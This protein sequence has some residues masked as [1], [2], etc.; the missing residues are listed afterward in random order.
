MAEFRGHII[1]NNGRNLLSRA[2]AGAGKII[3]TKAA[4]GD[5]KYNDNFKEVTA[6]K[7]KKLDLNVMG[8]R[9]D[10][11]T[12]IL[13]VFITNQDVTE[14]FLTQEF[15]IFAKIEG[16]ESDIL[17]AYTTAIA[18]DA[19]PNNK[20]GTTYESV[21]DIYLA[22]SNDIEADILVKDGVIFLTRDIADQ[23]YTK[24]EYPVASLLSTSSNLKAEHLYADNNGNWYLNIGGER[25]WDRN[26]TP[27][28]NLIKL[29]FRTLYNFYKK[30]FSLLTTKEEKE[31]VT[32][33]TNGIVGGTL[34]PSFIQDSGTKTQGQYYLD[35]NTGKLFQCIQT[36]SSTINSATF[37]K[38]VSLN[39]IVDRL[40]N[41]YNN[42]VESGY[43]KIGRL[44]IQWGYVKPGIHTFPIPFP[45]QVL[46][47]ASSGSG[48]GNGETTSLYII[49][50]NKFNAIQQQGK[51][52]RYIAVGY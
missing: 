39:G 44:I 24:N 13:T 38:D 32:L 31:I 20:F 49:D 10:N 40:E 36:T 51:F 28:N 26:P 50:K 48:S 16:D 43:Y 4:F 17:F 11:G 6:L 35:R 22:F 8:V 41:L 25:N 47:I 29:S 12:A 15:G 21:N 9:N 14:T 33:K 45:N 27:D 1:T 5:Q 37:F 34:N 23:V 18:A 52:Q 3:F 7:N 46:S 19:I 30:I 42:T 2:L